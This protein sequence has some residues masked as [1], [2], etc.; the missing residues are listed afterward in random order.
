MLSSSYEILARARPFLV[1]RFSK[2][3]LT[4]ITD[5][6]FS[7][8]DDEYVAD[9]AEA[10][11]VEYYGVQ[12]GE[13]STVP[14]LV[15][16]VSDLTIEPPVRPE[17]P[18][19]APHIL[20]DLCVECWHKNPK[21]RPTIDE[22]VERLTAAVSPS[23]LTQQ[24]VNRSTV[25]DSI[26]PHHVQQALAK[27]ETVPPEKYEDVTVIFSDIVGFTATSSVLSAEEVG[28][29]ISRLFTKF[30]SLAT[31]YGVKKLDVIGDAFLGVSGIPNRLA[32]HAPRAA[33]F[34]L[35]A[36]EA[37]SETPI[38]S[39]K[40]QLGTVR[41]RFGLCSGP[42]VAAVIGSAQHPKYTLF[43]NTVN[44]ASRMESTSEANRVQCTEETANLIQEQS[45]TLSVEH[46]EM[47]EIKGRGELDTYF[48]NLP[49]DGKLP[50]F[51]SSVERTTRR[52]STG[53]LSDNSSSFGANPR[54]FKTKK[55]STLSSSGMEETVDEAVPVE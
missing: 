55:T 3:T 53:D 45:P 9:P 54:A 28:D 17:V 39:A 18:D 19:D 40:P 41:V 31:K 26:L 43:G 32:D 47:M 23:S 44:T 7:E 24:L 8:S 37:A 52:L 25:F 22:I 14:H 30:D 51:L 49:Q 6:V 46:R 29:L 20:R 13:K 33:C 35:A 5:S 27:G 1:R 34:A 4:E 16:L 11:R 2:S 15:S 12:N 42:V 10:E 36:I 21:R 50:E 38:C 48:L